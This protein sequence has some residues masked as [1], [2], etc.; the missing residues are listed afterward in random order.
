MRT[1]ANFIMKFSTI[2]HHHVRKSKTF[3]HFGDEKH[4]KNV[5]NATAQGMEALSWKR[6]CC[7]FGKIE[8]NWDENLIFE[9]KIRRGKVKQQ[10]EKLEK[11]IFSSRN[12]K[13]ENGIIMFLPPLMS[14]EW[15]FYAKLRVVFNVS[16]F[17]VAAEW[18][19]NSRK[20][21]FL[22]FAYRTKL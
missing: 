20:I 8:W 13:G 14:F 11:F 4:T 1:R 17:I 15:K 9:E 16:P 19:L 7:S 22:S 18:V 10:R 2:Q 5:N 21:W 3:F 6:C 12:A